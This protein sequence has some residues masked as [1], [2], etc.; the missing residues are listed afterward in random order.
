MKNRN[1][2]LRNKKEIKK[3][4]NKEIIV[5]LFKDIQEYS[6]IFKNIQEYLDSRTFDHEY[7]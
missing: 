2:K 6:R 5:I 4:R 1:K 7:I 3:L